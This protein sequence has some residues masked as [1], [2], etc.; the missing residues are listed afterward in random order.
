MPA[1]RNWAQVGL[2]NYPSLCH[3][4]TA[5]LLKQPGAI[6]VAPFISEIRIIYLVLGSFTVL[7][8]ALLRIGDY[9]DIILEKDL[10]TPKGILL[11]RW[12][13][14]GTESALVL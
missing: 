1:A 5:C 8:V 2:H 7:G 10:R 3:Y 14:S 4:S 9:V 12:P 11:Q 13:R 6:S